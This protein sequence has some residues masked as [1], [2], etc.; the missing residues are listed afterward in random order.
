M[1]LDKESPLLQ[2]PLENQGNLV[3][4]RD[5]VDLEDQGGQVVLEVLVVQE[6]LVNPENLVNLE[7]LVDH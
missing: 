7:L 2:A 3:V 1:F 5:L 4:L 6:A